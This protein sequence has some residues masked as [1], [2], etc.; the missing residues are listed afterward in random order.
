MC[1]RFHG[2][3]LVLVG[4]SGGA[5]GGEGFRASVGVQCLIVGV[6]LAAWRATAFCSLFAVWLLLLLVLLVLLWWLL[7]LLL[8]L[9]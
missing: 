8:P 2:N 3:L 5:R 9:L 1:T 6:I 7:P 4:W